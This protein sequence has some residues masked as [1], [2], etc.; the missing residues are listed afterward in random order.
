MTKSEELT[1]NIASQLNFAVFDICF[2][3][4]VKYGGGRHIILVTDPNDAR[5]L[6][7]VSRPE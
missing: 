1:A 5:M 4:S 2:A 6:Q 7:I 3:M